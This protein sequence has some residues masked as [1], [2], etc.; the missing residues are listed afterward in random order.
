MDSYEEVWKA[1]DELAATLRAKGKTVPKEVVE[2]LRSAKTLI[3][4]YSLDHSKLE[5]LSQI[6]A[7]LGNVEQK[8]FYLAEADFGKEFADKYLEKI[9]K[10]R[11][12]T[13][14]P[15]KAT[16]SGLIPGLPRDQHWIRVKLDEDIRRDELEALADSLSL[17]CK[18]QD[19]D[20]LL[21]Y[22]EENK[23]KRLIRKVA[24]ERKRS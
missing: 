21:I 7:Y 24:E 4:V 15:E 20:F 9:V 1:L 10:A 22:G 2:D 6:E 18:T 16:P 12:K 8:L 13:Q 14:T 5:T 23:I 11:S 17:S 3:N 19:K